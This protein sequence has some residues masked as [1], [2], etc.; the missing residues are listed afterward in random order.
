M[1]YADW[2]AGQIWDR[3]G[4]QL[5]QIHLQAIVPV[6][7]HP[8]RLAERGYNQAEWIAKKLGVRMEIP[9]LSHGL[10]RRQKTTAQKFLG[11]GE[12]SH[13]L[14]SVFAPGRQSVAGLTVLLVDD[15]Y[16]TGA[17]AENC[18]EVLLAAGATAV[19]LVNVCIG[20]EEG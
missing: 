14:E 11:A 17:T 6:P 10:R 18:T 19:Y 20:E 8:S 2:Y 4:T 15:I 16:T 9:V 1:E 5:K 12:R 3:Y 13:N 7:L